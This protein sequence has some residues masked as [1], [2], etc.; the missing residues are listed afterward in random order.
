MVADL[1][2]LG[3]LHSRTAKDM[4]RFVN[5]GDLIDRSKDP[6]LPAVIDVSKAQSFSYGTLDVMACA[7]A[8]GLMRDGYQRGDRIAILSSNRVEYLAAYF[9]IMRAGLVAVPVSNRFPAATIR[10]VLSDC[11][12]RLVFADREGCGQLEADVPVVDFDR[13]GANGYAS[14]LDPGPFDAVVPAPREPAMFLYTSGSTGVPKGVVLSHQSHLWVT[15]KRISGVDFSAHRLLVAAPLFH[16]N[17]LSVCKMAIAGH[18]TIVMLPRFTAKA[19]LAAIAQHQCTWLTGVPTMI[20]MALQERDM[21]ASIDT[22]RVRIV[23][24]GSAP[25]SQGAAAAALKAFPNATLINGY[26]STEAG[27]VI[28]AP[29]PDK[30]PTPLGSV[31]YQHPEV[32]LRLGD[33]ADGS[34]A[35]GVLQVKCPGLMNEY[36]NMPIK[37]AEVFTKDGFYI[38]G[39]VM[40]RD[41]LG[42]FYFIG[43]EDDMFFCGGENI[44][45][46]EVE[47][48]LERHPDVTQACVVPFDDDIKGA[49]PFAFIIRK[50]GAQV[51]AE[52]LKQFALENAPAYQHP[53]GIEFIAAM[54]LTGTGKI[55]RQ[56]LAIR[57]AELTGAGTKEEN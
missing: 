36:H 10:Y 28:F 15:E 4:S 39:D 55:D 34:S 17:A 1:H 38:S 56:I 46:R 26:G 20:A 30:V 23:R 12:A 51:S 35:Q 21:L 45:P 3:E 14:R 57:A 37:T 42:F 48:M 33:G 13:Q 16:M 24:V 5:L 32:E 18:G 8:R 22:S 6:A 19:Y 44:F 31:G 49:K 47:H 2:A 52:E 9:G 40:R 25:L 41:E 43:R 54:P 53:R 7:V 29:H 11:G 50:E 27:P